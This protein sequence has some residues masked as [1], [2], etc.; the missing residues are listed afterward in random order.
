MNARTAWSTEAAPSGVTEW[1]WLVPAPEGAQAANVIASSREPIR[2]LRERNK[3][4][5]TRVEDDIENLHRPTARI[6][7]YNTKGI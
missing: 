1:E 3:T 6:A 4:G 5:R 2:N 7:R